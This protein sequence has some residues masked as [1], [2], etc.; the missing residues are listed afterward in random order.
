MITKINVTTDNYDDAISMMKM[1][2]GDIIIVADCGTVR[3]SFAKTLSY[4]AM[5]VRKT[6]DKVLIDKE[7]VRYH[8]YTKGNV[9]I[10][11]NV[12][13]NTAVN[14]NCD[15]TDE[16]YDEFKPFMQDQANPK[17]THITLL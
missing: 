1:G 3:D 11:R 16:W 7:Y 4:N 15:M 14:I 2:M 12:N 9:N 17:H 5:D 13:F 6:L 8:V 10:G